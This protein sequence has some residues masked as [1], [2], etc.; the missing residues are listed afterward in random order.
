MEGIVK[1]ERHPLAHEKGGFRLQDPDKLIPAATK[2]IMKK[3]GSKL[4]KLQFFDL[5]KISGPAKIAYPATYLECFLND[6]TYFPRYMEA[7]CNTEDNIERIKNVTTWIIAGLHVG[8]CILQALS[9]LNPILGET[10]Q[11][12]AE[13]GTKYYAE[14]ITHHPPISAAVMEGPEGKWRF[15]VIQEFKASLNGHNSVKAHKEGA[16]VLTLYDGTQYLVEEGWINIE[17]LVYGELVINVWGQI[18]VRDVTHN[19]V[20]EVTFDPDNQKGMLKNVASKLKF[21]GAKKT[22]RP[23]DHFDIRIY[24]ENG[25]KKE[26]FWTGKGSYL[27]YVEFEGSST[28]YWEIGDE[29]TQ[30]L[31]PDEKLLLQSD[32]CL[33]QDINFIKE[34]DYDNA[35]EAKEK[36]EEQQRT[37]KALRQSKAKK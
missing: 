25:D 2:D 19:I 4:A 27:E 21:W 6:Y 13:D 37:D 32:S 14:Q 12:Y 26:I 5:M 36:L 7:V 24:E 31:K 10:C 3:V 29:W 34:K 15:E 8:E 9:P 23:S 1:G 18:T 30:W 11:R 16:L 33:R 35:Q 22:K 17:G 28:K 20:S